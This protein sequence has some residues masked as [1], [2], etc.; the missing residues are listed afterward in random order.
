MTLRPGLPLRLVVE[1]PLGL[2]LAGVWVRITPEEDDAVEVVGPDA[3][4]RRTREDGT[5]VLL[6]L[7]DRAW[8]VQLSLPGHADAVLHDV[9]PGPAVHFVTLV[10]RDR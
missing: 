5:L 6:D 3:R 2:P 7:P 1:S 4:P 8:R 10:P 9:R